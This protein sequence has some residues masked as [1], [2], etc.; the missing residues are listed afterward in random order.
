LNGGSFPIGTT[1]VTCSATDSHH[2]TRTGSFQVHVKGAAE[3]LADLA[4][5]AR[6]VGRGPLLSLTIATAQTLLSHN[7]VPATCVTLSAFIAEVRLQAGRSIPG[8]LAT[9]LVADAQRIRAVLGC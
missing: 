6:G 4:A 7:H 3:Q 9:S 1:T 2:N 5:R 8:A